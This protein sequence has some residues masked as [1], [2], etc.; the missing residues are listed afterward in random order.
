MGKSLQTADKL[1]AVY[2]LP[3]PGPVA[4][5]AS[6]RSIRPA[7]VQPG[8][9]RRHLHRLLVPAEAAEAAGRAVRPPPRRR[10][11]ILC[12]AWSDPWR[13]HRLRFVLQPCPLPPAPDRNREVVGRRHV[14]P[15]RNRSGPRS[16]SSISR[17]R[18]SCRG[19]GSTITSPAASR[20]AVLRP[21]GQLREPGT[22]GRPNQFPW[23]VRFVEMTPL[24]PALGPASSEPAL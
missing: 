24:G 14:L 12:S 19:S 9:S 5:R 18:R 7:L 6:Y 4:D 17:A 1:L 15:R 23:A 16:G 13:P 3:G 10:S 20:S 22:V 8:L 11:G 2:Q 21:A